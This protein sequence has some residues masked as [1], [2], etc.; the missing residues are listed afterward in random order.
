MGANLF[1]RSYTTV[2]SSDSDYLI[3]TKGQIKV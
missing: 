1:G 2:G 3:K